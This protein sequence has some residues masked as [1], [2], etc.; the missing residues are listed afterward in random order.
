MSAIPN[1]KGFTPDVVLHLGCIES[2]V[3]RFRLVFYKLNQIYSHRPKTLLL[4]VI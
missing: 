1:P 3:V 4:V 2:G